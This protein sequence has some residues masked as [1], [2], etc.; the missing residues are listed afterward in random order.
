VRGV[1]DH[2]AIDAETEAESIAI[3]GLAGRFPGAPDVSSSTRTSCTSRVRPPR[4]R[5]KDLFA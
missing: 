1:N 5:L 2:S 3:I 4:L